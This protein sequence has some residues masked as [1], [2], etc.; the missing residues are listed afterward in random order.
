M[1]PHI[2]ENERAFLSLTYYARYGRDTL[3]ILHWCRA[4]LYDYPNVLHCVDQ[5][6]E[7]LKVIAY[8]KEDPQRILEYFPYEEADEIMEDI[9]VE[10]TDRCKLLFDKLEDNNKKCEIFDLFVRVGKYTIQ[11]M[12]SSNLPLVHKLKL[13]SNCAEIVYQ[14][15]ESTLIF[16]LKSSFAVSTLKELSYQQ[17]IRYHM[18]Q[19]DEWQNLKSVLQTVP[20]ELNSFVVSSFA[21]DAKVHYSIQQHLLELYSSSSN[22]V[23]QVSS[24]C[25]Y[26]E[27]NILAFF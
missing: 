15:L 11:D 21:R 20:Q 22:K 8:H 12:N 19:P 14:M 18:K 9:L 10:V 6:I 25:I 1:P 16:P 17:I 27:T 26:Y 3:D 13:P 23:P 2:F 5:F 24:L 4:I 7:I